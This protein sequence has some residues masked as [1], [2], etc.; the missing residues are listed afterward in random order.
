MA[1]TLDRNNCAHML[2]NSV[3]DRSADVER[4]YKCLT[5]VNDMLVIDTV[6]TFNQS[7]NGY[8]TPKDLSIH[9]R[10]A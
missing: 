4:C 8:T 10:L 1:V 6:Y 9:V 2:V 7:A 3:I 5:E